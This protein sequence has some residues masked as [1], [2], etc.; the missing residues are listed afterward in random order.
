MHVGTGEETCFQP[1]LKMRNS[2][3]AAIAKESQGAT[4]NSHGDWTFLRPHE[5]VPEVPS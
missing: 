3:L 1:Q 5:L 2:V 4:H